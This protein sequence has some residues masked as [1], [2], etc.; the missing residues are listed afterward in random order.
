MTTPFNMQVHCPNCQTLHTWET[1]FGRWIRNNKGL[2]SSLGYCVVDQDYWVH[3]FKTYR[4]REF[5]LIMLVEIKVLGQNL[6]LAQKDTL[7]QVNQVMR[8]RRR[9]PTKGLR[10]QSGESIIR[11]TYSV[12]HKRKIQLRVYGM[13]VLRFSGLGPDDSEMITWDQTKIDV[14]MLTKI[15]RFD[16]D[17]DTLK[18]IDLRSHHRTTR[19]RQLTMDVDRTRK[20]ANP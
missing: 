3:R 7:H 5:Q 11:E 6:T 9:T 14:D 15:L 13:H 17:P 18:P 1:M 19:V 8:N 12:V 16:I 2:D 20:E 4:G 10:W